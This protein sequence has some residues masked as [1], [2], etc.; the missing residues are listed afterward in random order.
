MNTRPGDPFANCTCLWWHTT[1][2]LSG[3]ESRDPNCPQHGSPARMQ[4]VSDKYARGHMRDKTN[5]PQHGR[6]DS[7]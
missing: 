7:K 4:E 5:C 3:I 1:N 2:G 6:K